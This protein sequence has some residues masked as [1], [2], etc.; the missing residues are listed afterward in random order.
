MSDSTPKKNDQGNGLMVSRQER[1]RQIEEEKQC[2]RDRVRNTNAE[3]EAEYYS[4]DPQPAIDDD[5]P[6]LVAAYTRV[7]T[8]SLDQ[9]S[10]IENQPKYYTEKFGKTPNWTMYQIYSDEGKSGTSMRKREA[11]RQMIQDAA[12]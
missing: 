4:A 6:K 5:S 1:K 7:S 2:R 3:P 12:A 11:F 9:V 8:S 10:S